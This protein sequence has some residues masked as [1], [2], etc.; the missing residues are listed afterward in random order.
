M[1]QRNTMQ[2]RWIHCLAVTA[3]A[4]YS[5]GYLSAETDAES[6]TRA[7]EVLFQQF[8]T[9]AYSS[10]DVLSRFDKAS[11]N[12]PQNEANMVLPL[13]LRLPFVQLIG[14]LR[15]LGPNTM[16]ELQSNYSGVLVGAKGFTPPAGFGMVSS[17]D[18]YIGML[19]PQGRSLVESYF[20]QSTFELI[21]GQRVWTWSAPPYEGYPHSTTFYLT[22]VEHTYFV[23]GNDLAEFRATVRRLT[24]EGT[25]DNTK[26]SDPNASSD[27]KYWVYRSI[28][29]NKATRD[30]D[31]AGLAKV[32]STIAMRFAVDF[33][34]MTGQV[35]ADSADE[36]LKTI[37]ELPASEVLHYEPREAG[38]WRAA[39]PI[40]EDPATTTALF[41]V[42]S[43][44]GFGVVL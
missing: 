33:E 12:T 16:T 24:T 23:I 5:F 19:R 21:D 38:T 36:T 34:T 22:V 32:T 35:E 44:F 9:V 40:A 2:S 4:L 26:I 29:W 31:P 7:A 8:E 6:R 18:C 43:L 28:R 13:A 1:Q 17:Q 42:F 10:T 20:S 15:L 14:G 41:T 37:K 11:V 25:K 30:V 39:V 3:I 27:K